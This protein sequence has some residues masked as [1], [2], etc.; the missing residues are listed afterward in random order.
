MYPLPLFI[1][2]GTVYRETVSQNISRGTV[3]RE[4]VSQ[5]DIIYAGALFYPPPRYVPGYWVP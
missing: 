4:T 1:S 5:Y 3:F 2:R